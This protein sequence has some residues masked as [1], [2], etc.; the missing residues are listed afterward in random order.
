MLNKIT[1]MTYY[2]PATVASK[3]YSTEVIV[4]ISVQIAVIHNFRQCL[5]KIILEEMF[6]ARPNLMGP[7]C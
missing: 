7:F 5:I 2:L 4:Q 1:N 6:A 3:L